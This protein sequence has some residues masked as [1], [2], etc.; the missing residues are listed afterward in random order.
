MACCRRHVCISAAGTFSLCLLP[1][2]GIYRILFAAIGA[3]VDPN[4]EERGLALAKKNRGGA[5]QRSILDSRDSF[6]DAWNAV[7]E[8]PVDGLLIISATL[9]HPTR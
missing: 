6:H 9:W 5:G 8:I 2:V 4:L 3:L 1:L 7:S